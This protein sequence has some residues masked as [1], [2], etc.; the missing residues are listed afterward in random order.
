MTRS[1]Q[2][3]LDLEAE[4]RARVRVGCT[5]HGGCQSCRTDEL[6]DE[7]E[8]L[9]NNLLSLQEEFHDAQRSVGGDSNNPRSGESS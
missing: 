4:G 8:R 3:W 7:V 6:Q 1:Y 9:R 2:D 5:Q